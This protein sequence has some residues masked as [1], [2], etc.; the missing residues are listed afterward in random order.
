MLQ[1]SIPSIPVVPKIHQIPLEN[2]K[3]WMIEIDGKAEKGSAYH[4]PREIVDIS[5][6][7]LNHIGSPVDIYDVSDIQT[8]RNLARIYSRTGK[9]RKFVRIR[10]Y[11]SAISKYIQYADFCFE[12]PGRY[13]EF[14]GRKFRY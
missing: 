12:N 6:H 13:A 8:V 5:K 11:A 3:K 14:Y 1:K 2:F 7:Y 9:Y 4:Y 10:H